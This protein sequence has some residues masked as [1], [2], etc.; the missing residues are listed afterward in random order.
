MREKQYSRHCSEHSSGLQQAWN[1]ERA[2]K[3]KVETWKTIMVGLKTKPMVETCMDS[4]SFCII[5]RWLNLGVGSCAQTRILHS[6]MSLDMFSNTHTTDPSFI[7]IKK[8]KSLRKNPFAIEQSQG[9]SGSRIGVS[10]FKLSNKLH[11]LSSSLTGSIQST[12]SPIKSIHQLSLQA[13]NLCQLFQLLLPLLSQSNRRAFIFW[14]PLVL[15]H[16][17]NQEKIPFLGGL[18]SGYQNSWFQDRIVGCWVVLDRV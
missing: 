11:N 1:T 6:K 17:L 7:Y 16:S 4:I 15:I 5:I 14:T 10:G 2:R 8:K 3:V 13:I 9:L 18:F 12:I